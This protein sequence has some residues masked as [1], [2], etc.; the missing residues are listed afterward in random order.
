AIL[1][2]IFGVLLV[3]LGFK[4]SGAIAASTLAGIISF[5]LILV[6]L[7]FLFNKK[8]KPVDFDSS[9][10]YKFFW[11]V[12]ITILCFTILINVDVIFVKHFFSPK[13]AGYYSAASLMG[14]IVLFFPASF[15]MVMFSKTSELHAQ[16]EQSSHVLKKSLLLVGLM[17]VAI[18]IGYFVFPSFLISII[19][20]QKYLASAKWL[21]LFGIAMCMFSLINILIH[22]YLSVQKLRFIPILVG[23]TI[24]QV[25]VLWFVPFN[26]TQIIYV[27]IGISSLLLISFTVVERSSVKQEGL[28][29]AVER[30]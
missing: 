7:K 23:A 28:R 18:T 25:G 11:P 6:P 30:V 14:K 20:G 4:A 19:Y 22:Y 24:L 5:L 13:Q 2:L 27:L 12:L 15:A 17:C 29:E 9:E 16:N 26:P 3:Y 10:I 1:R 8:G 21:G